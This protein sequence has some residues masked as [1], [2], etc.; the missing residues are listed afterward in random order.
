MPTVPE[1]SLCTKKGIAY[2][3]KI[4]TAGCHQQSGKNSHSNTTISSQLF[5]QTKINSLQRTWGKCTHIHCWQERKQAQPFGRWF[6]SIYK[7]L[8]RAFT[9][10]QQFHFYVYIP[11]NYPCVHLETYTKDGYCSF[12]CNS[13]TAHQLEWLNIIAHSCDEI[14]HS[15]LKM[16]CIRCRDIEEFL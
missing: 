12:S 5:K 8:K 7:I 6:G 9:S 16:R 4:F 3:G 10:A 2:L 11:E 13:L 15:H 14:S 1:P